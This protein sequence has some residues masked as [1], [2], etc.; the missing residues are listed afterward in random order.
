MKKINARNIK[1]G[2]TMYLVHALAEHSLLTQVY[3][4]G[5]PVAG[6]YSDSL[7]AY[8]VEWNG[9]RSY[10]TEFSLTDMNIIPNGYNHHRAFY[11]KKRAK[12]YLQL[13]QT[14]GIG[15]SV[16]DCA[17]DIGEAMAPAYIEEGW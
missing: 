3:L 8:G 13:C 15:Q 6:Y 14:C 1:Q 10:K 12:A 11:S 2:R 5:R 9:R 16:V 4:G 7:F 17:E